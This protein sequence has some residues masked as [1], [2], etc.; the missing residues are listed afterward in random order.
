MQNKYDVIVIGAGNSGMAAAATAA[1]HGKKTL[2]IEKHGLP[3]GASTSFKRGRFEFEVALHEMAGVGTKEKPNRVRKMFDEFG[4]KID[5]CQGEELFRAVLPGED[6]FDVVL[7]CDEQEF[8]ETM[9]KAVPGCRESMVKMFDLTHE[10]MEARA[11]MASPE[12]TQAEMFKRYP[13]FLAMAS[14]STFEVLDAIGMPKRAQ[15]II[16]GYWTYVGA[17]LSVF[18]GMLYLGMLY[19]YMHDKPSMPPKRSHE[20]SLAFDKAI[21]DHGGEIWYNCEV[22]K[23]ITENGKAVGVETNGK[24]VYADKIFCSASPNHVYANLLDQATLPETAI[25]LSNARTPA[26]QLITTYVGL[27]RSAEE[28][29]IKDYSVFFYTTADSVDQF[30]NA[31]GNLGTESIYIANC[32]NNVVPDSS[33]EG[34]CT[35]FFTA[36]CYGDEWG[37]VSP[38]D[39]KKAKTMVAERML[40]DYE[41]TL[42][43]KLR[44][45]IEEITT[46]GAPTFARYLGTPTGSPYGYQVTSWDSMLPRQFCQDKENF[47][48]GLYFIGAHGTAVDGFNSSYNSGYDTVM[49]YAFANTEKEEK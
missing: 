22:T 27:N 9:E 14:H 29:G 26:V 16:G 47:V 19:T 49:R 24:S 1:V 8:I 5:F 35:L 18:D 30:N 17:P 43:I 34:T 42:G 7:P 23:I 2:L 15:D 46:T 45:Y 21:R 36:L 28:L 41:K 32:L 6:G 25:K 37:K 48:P 38:R 39:Y 40:D 20:I 4:M 33:P 10:I 11:F 13:N 12:F 44:P 3:G 31:F